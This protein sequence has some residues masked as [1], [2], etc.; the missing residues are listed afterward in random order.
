MPHGHS[1]HTGSSAGAGKSAGSNTSTGGGSVLSRVL[2]SLRRRSHNSDTTLKDKEDTSWANN[3]KITHRPDRPRFDKRDGLKSRNSA[4]V[5]GQLH[6]I[7]RHNQKM[8]EAKKREREAREVALAAGV[9]RS[10]DERQSNRDGEFDTGRPHP[11]PSLRT[12]QMS[13]FSG[14]VDSPG[15]NRGEWRAESEVEYQQPNIYHISAYRADKHNTYP[16]SSPSIASDR[17]TIRVGL[18]L[19]SAEGEG[20]SYWH[21]K[22]AP[23]LPHLPAT[24]YTPFT[25]PPQPVSA[26]ISSPQKESIRRRQ[27]H[28]L[29]R[30]SP[31]RPPLAHTIQASSA[32][33]KALRESMALY[34]NTDQDSAPGFIINSSLASE[35]VSPLTPMQHIR[36][37]I[38]DNR[39]LNLKPSPAKSRVCPMP[40][41]RNHLITSIDQ[42]QNLCATCRSEHQP[43]QSIFITDVLNAFPGPYSPLGAEFSSRPPLISD[44][45]YDLAP[46][47]RT[48][49]P[50]R[51]IDGERDT[52]ASQRV[53]INN[54]DV[55]SRLNKDRGGFK[56]QSAPR[57]RKHL[58]REQHLSRS[59]VKRQIAKQAPSPVRGGHRNKSGNGKSHIG[60]QRA[61]ETPRPTTTTTPP[62][63]P[64]SRNVAAVDSRPRKT[65]GPF[66][67]PRTFCP[68]PR[69]AAR[70]DK[71]TSPIAHRR[72]HSNLRSLA[73]SAQASATVHAG[74]STDYTPAPSSAPAGHRR[75]DRVENRVSE[76]TR[77]PGRG[78]ALKSEKRKAEEEDIYREIDSII[79][80]YL[81]LSEAPEPVHEKRKAEAVASYFTVPSEVEMSL[82]GFI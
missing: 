14:K 17:M 4:Y 69:P 2:G 45:S 46:E 11:L 34:V 5:L 8:L 64:S 71:N 50:S 67:E 79:D 53:I 38:R 60:F 33:S 29:S 28:S 78:P 23:E 20:D 51:G 41:C 40:L 10:I 57:S 37:D 48:L 31:Q 75:P 55:L 66:L 65:S 12:D 74:K 3:Y 77:E 27:T 81:R 30:S 56:L 39:Y 18:E 49:E 80:C 36:E 43:R 62:P 22:D 9:E 24:T 70:R 7:W 54:S 58:K 42:A 35:Q 32:R 21:T 15:F 6:K 73:K 16:P 72:R 76:P 61:A 68:A 47:E 19:E 44:E 52:S 63:H 1:P 82:K 13:N 26:S 59:P 25:A